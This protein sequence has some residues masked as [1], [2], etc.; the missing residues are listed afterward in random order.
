MGHVVRRIHETG[1]GLDRH[2]APLRGTG[3]RAV[4]AGVA[5]AVVGGLLLVVAPAAP[6]LLAVAVVGV[7]LG[8]AGLLT[9]SSLRHLRVVAT[10]SERAAFRERCLLG[11]SRQM[12]RASERHEVDQV[13][14]D[15]ARDLVDQRRSRT[16]VWEEQDDVWVAIASA[17]PSRLEVA[18]SSK[19]PVGMLERM[20][21][22]E[23]WVL[24]EAEAIELQR[25]YDLDPLYRS[26]VYLPL[27]R[28][29]GPR[30]VLALSCPEPPDADLPDALR[31]FV[32]EV[33]VAEDRA[34]L[35]GE[36]AA[37][38]AELASLLQGSTDII[39]MVD[40]EAIVTFANRA[41]RAQW[42]YRPDDLV[43]TNIFDVFHPDDRGR[44]LR[45]TLGGDLEV[46]VKVAHRMF[47]A[48]GNQRHVETWVSRPDGA[49][50]GYLLNVRDVT[51]RKELEAEIRHQAM[52]DPLTGLANRRVFTARLDEALERFA[53]TGT[54]V[55]VI[56]LD[57]D[58]FKPIN[59]TWGH[60]AGDEA[61]VEIGRR[62][63]AAVRT[64][65]VAARM[66]G[67][68]FAVVLEAA[69]EPNEV[70]TLAARLDAAVAAPITLGRG[71]ECRVTASLGIASSWAG[72]SG[73]ELLR[74][75]D[76]QLYVS[77]GARLDRDRLPPAHHA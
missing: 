49:S 69:G 38:E 57:L 44:V 39:A 46:G 51:E 32:Q 26:F 25:A 1:E 77:K 70:A 8:A 18:S 16:I 21:A 12:A 35:L 73:D 2:T 5:A 10:R 7:A 4:M 6:V 48:A 15:V 30:A 45:A 13:V 23:P 28:P 20:A 40:E 22:G 42:G 60:Q 55:G 27:P 68:E 9:L 31:R 50:T 11:A 37:R 59:D 56:M 41:T 67:D 3:R 14:A 58:D 34:R 64:T 63:R 53:R 76:Q 66:G 19:L 62:L 74:E 33:A 36:L 65:D 43:G 54:P 17:G 75:A 29:R 72:C 71:I 24:D 52:H 47:D 61:L